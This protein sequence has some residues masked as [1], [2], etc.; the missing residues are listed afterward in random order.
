MDTLGSF[1]NAIELAAR[2]GHADEDYELLELP[3]SPD[4]MSEL[5][6]YFNME[7]RSARL[8]K[9]LPDELSRMAAPL[10][11]WLSLRGVCAM[12][13]YEITLY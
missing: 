6:Q 12:M 13:P 5:R 4:W 1:E 8:K 9:A 11:R 7:M 3:E 2:L 10:G